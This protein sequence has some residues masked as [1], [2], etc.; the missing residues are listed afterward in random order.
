MN[1]PLIAY[2]LSH[3]SNLVFTAYDFSVIAKFLLTIKTHSEHIFE[4]EQSVHNRRRAREKHMAKWCKFA[5]ARKTVKVLEILS[6][7][8]QT[9]FQGLRENP[10]HDFKSYCGYWVKLVSFPKQVDNWIASNSINNDIRF[11]WVCQ[12][13]KTKRIVQDRATSFS[14]Q[15]K[16]NTIIKINMLHLASLPNKHAKAAKK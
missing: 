13:N 3:I 15:T 2:K 14:F 5:T 4:C 7:T 8:L 6:A 10:W 1:G 9:M 11:D 16:L 12:W